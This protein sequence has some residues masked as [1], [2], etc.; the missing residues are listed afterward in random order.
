M[1]PEYSLKAEGYKKYYLRQEEI[2]E[3]TRLV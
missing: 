3:F 2:Y 1:K